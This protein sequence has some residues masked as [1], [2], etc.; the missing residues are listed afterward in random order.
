MR[1]A[2]IHP[3]FL[4][5]GGGERVTGVL[6]GMYPKADVF[7]LFSND[8]FLPSELRGR[9]V[10][11][12]F[13]EWLPGAHRFYRQLMP[14][15]AVG[16]ESLDVRGYDLVISSCS[17]VSKGVLP[18]QSAV[19][20]S[21]CHTPTR[22]L[23]DYYRPFL[24]QRSPLLRPAFA[25]SAHYMRIWDYQAAQR[26]DQ[27]AA[28]SYFIANRIRKYYRRDSTVIYPPIDTKIG[29]LERQ[30]D[31]YYLSVGR[32]THTKRIDLLIQA[33]NR[34]GRRLVVAG[35]GR[36]MDSLKR[37]AGPNIEFLGRVD[38]AS[39]PELYA[40]CRAFLFA[41]EEDLGMVPLEAQSYGRP[42]I[43]FKKGG[44][45]ETVRGYADSASPTGIFF[46]NQTVEDVES[47]ILQYEQVEGNF[48]PS[49]IRAH[50]VTFD[51]SVFIHKMS[52]FINAAM[53]HGKM[54]ELKCA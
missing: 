11:T 2:I 3:W 33:C 30:H 48:A 43:A 23:W 34:L 35:A 50:A 29:Y 5:S 17:S 4:F 49:Q 15:H 52:A 36:K 44:S 26:V 46:E 18:D 53:H 7:A 24:R 12:S 21:Y 8:R 38:D 20:V 28:N 13:L 40:K 27:Y 9:D 1:V 45:L 6:A 22:F 37:M 14:L 19:H 42:V 39:L 32:L 41:A 51:T 25:A 54:P 31:N 16:A 47:A 10:R